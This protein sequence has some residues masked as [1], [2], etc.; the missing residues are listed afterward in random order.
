M[1]KTS[2]KITVLLMAVL[3]VVSLF[4][5]GAFAAEAD[6]MVVI[7]TSLAVYPAAS[8]LFYAPHD[9]PV[10]LVDPGDPSLVGVKNPLTHIKKRSAEGTPELVEML[11]NGVS[12]K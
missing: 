11:I 7:G 12:E 3:L 6:L 4:P 5:M 9:A 1:R 2:L 8:L 10:W